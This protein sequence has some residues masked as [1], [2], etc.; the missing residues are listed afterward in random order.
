MAFAA[1]SGADLLAAID[2]GELSACRD[3]FLERCA[4]AKTRSVPEKISSEGGDTCR[5]SVG[6]EVPD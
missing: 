4:R 1:A 6:G 2:S 5:L 3:I